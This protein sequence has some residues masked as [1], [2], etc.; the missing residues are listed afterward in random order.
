MNG[1]TQTSN[2]NP[3]TLQ[4]ER[5]GMFTLRLCF[6]NPLFQSNL[7][8]RETPTGST[9]DRNMRVGTGFRFQSAPGTAIAKPGASDCAIGVF[10]GTP[11]LD[12]S[13]GCKHSSGLLVSGIKRQVQRSGVHLR[14]R[15]WVR[16]RV[17]N[18]QMCTPLK[19][20]LHPL[21]SRLTTT[22][23]NGR[24][25]LSWALLAFLMGTTSLH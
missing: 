21:L 1:G 10:G 25:G 22:D 6:K 23:S 18:L 19:F 4:G 11:K 9:K 17:L 3:I 2:L 24:A 7:E 12:Y 5:N 15:T 13:V 16:E 8:E 14:I 20:V